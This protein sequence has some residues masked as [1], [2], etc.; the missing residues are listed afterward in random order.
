MR[1]L[2]MSLRGRPTVVG[3]EV[4]RQARKPDIVRIYSREGLLSTRVRGS[5]SL[6]T[7]LER[8]LWRLALELVEFLEDLPLLVL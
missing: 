1:C 4:L 3:A 2:R 5:V 7:T 8:F 6:E